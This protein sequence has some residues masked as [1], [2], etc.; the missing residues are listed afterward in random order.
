[1][2]LYSQYHSPFTA[3]VRLACYAKG[4]TVDLVE[5]PDGTG[6]AAFKEISPLGLI[7][8]LEL[9]NGTVIPESEVILEYLED[10]F[11]DPGLRPKDL[12]LRSRARLIAQFCDE[13][14]HAPLK[15]VV[16]QAKAETTDMAIVE[17]HLPALKE[18][19]SF[20]DHYIEGS[21]YA[22]AEQ[23]TFADCALVPL[24]FF[25]DLAWQ[26]LGLP[27]AYNDT[28]KLK[29]YWKGVGQ[30][31]NV[32]RVLGEMAEAQDISV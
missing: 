17:A 22:V 11:P 21:D 13:Y 31:G 26:R 30:D 29:D 3:R 24:L 12:V 6:S 23:L 1:M 2:K 16:Y 25:V 9:G 27:Y 32:A 14:L 10:A 4:L 18:A 15:E 20:I 8:A 28:S 7:P 19:L 5:P